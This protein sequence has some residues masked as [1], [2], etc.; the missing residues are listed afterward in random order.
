MNTTSIIRPDLEAEL[1]SAL[2]AEAQ[3]VALNAEADGR[4]NFPTVRDGAEQWFLE[5]HLA[6][7]KLIAL[8]FSKLQMGSRCLHVME[9]GEVYKDVHLQLDTRERIGKGRLVSVRQSLRG[10]T[11]GYRRSWPYLLGA[12]ALSLFD[13][14]FNEGFIAHQLR[15]PG[16]VSY[17]LSLVVGGAFFALAHWGIPLLRSSR[18]RAL[19]RYGI[20]G[21]LIAVTAI[22]YVMA[23]G[24][25]VARGMH[26][27]VSTNLQYT[28]FSLLLFGVACLLS[29]LYHKGKQGLMVHTAAR[30][31]TLKREERVLGKELRETARK[32]EELRIREQEER[33][34]ARQLFEYG[35]GL[36]RMVMDEAHQAYCIY[37]KI[38]RLTRTDHELPPSMRSGDYPFTFS[39]FY[40]L[41]A[42]QPP[43]R[44][45]SYLM[46]LVAVLLL[47][48]TACRAPESPR[49]QDAPLSLFIDQTDSF[50]IYPDS[51]QV[52][53]MLHLD[54]HL[55]DEAQIMIGT[56]TD[57]DVN[58]VSTFILPK[59]DPLMGNLYNRADAMWEFKRNVFDLLEASR[60]QGPVTPLDHS[61]IYLPLVRHMTY[62]LQAG[63]EHPTIAVYSDLN[64]HSRIA[65]FYN[66]ETL[67]KLQRSP[68]AEIE[69]FEQ[70]AP[71]P[72]LAG[73]VL[74]FVYQPRNFEDSNRYAITSGFFKRLFEQHGLTVHIVASL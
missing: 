61:S 12:L 1:G 45:P 59:E 14:I 38:N 65:N 18:H 39:T 13:G 43:F 42:E 7:D 23:A 41:S 24:R 72:N 30:Y 19:R 8:I 66:T 28:G 68:E 25:Q 15:L 70:A 26:P 60:P 35:T 64:E 73:G 50:L 2:E 6:Y 5:H 52:K 17:I 74:Y 57:S 32:R 47:G 31:E 67:R 63:A 3:K 20:A 58:P 4:R 37:V 16:Y 21:V 49:V 10:M 46:T 56:I 9:A 22:F 34:R 53:R 27:T 29:H 33:E 44:I 69:R 48:A 51:N 55:F 62:L 11:T 71:I 40:D 36:R 54:E